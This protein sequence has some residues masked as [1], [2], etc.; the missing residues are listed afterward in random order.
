MGF[1]DAADDFLVVD[2]GGALVVDDQIKAFGVVRVSV[3]G[4]RGLGA[5][6]VGVDLDDLCVKTTLESFLEDV[7]LFGVVVA[8]AACYEEDPEGFGSLSVGIAQEQSEGK[9]KGWKDFHDGTESRHALCTFDQ[10]AIEL[11][12]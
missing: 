12:S 1:E 8:A 9:K 2:G 11:S 5:F 10:A 7:L 6:V 4:E 3:D